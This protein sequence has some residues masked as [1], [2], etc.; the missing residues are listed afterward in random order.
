MAN[1]PDDPFEKQLNQGRQAL[2]KDVLKG[3][4]RTEY[5]ARIDWIARY[6]AREGSYTLIPSTKETISLSGKR[7]GDAIRQPYLS[8]VRKLTG[9]S[10]TLDDDYPLG[11][12]LV[13]YARLT[14]GLE[15]VDRQDVDPG[16]VLGRLVTRELQRQS[17]D[18]DTQVAMNL[19]SDI[20]SPREL[21]EQIAS[22]PELADQLEQVLPTRAAPKELVDRLGSV[23]IATRLWDHQLDAL[24]EWIAADGNGYVN[25]A[26]ATGKTVLGL[27]AVGYCSDSGSLHPADQN[28]LGEQFAERFGRSTP[29]AIGQN[30]ASD[31]LIVTTDELL[32]VQWARL[33]REHCNTPPEYTRIVDQTISL[34]WGDVDIRS[35]NSLNGVDPRDYRLAIFDEVHNYSSRGGWG[36]H[37]GRFIDS[38]CPVLALTGSVEE[39]IEQQFQRA[40]RPFPQVYRYTHEDALEDGVIPDFEWTLL[41]AGIDEGRSSTLSKLQKTET[42]F[43]DH[44]DWNG[45]GVTIRE[46]SPEYASLP[47]QV[48][49]ELAESPKSATGLGRALKTAGSKETAPTETLETLATGLSSRRTFWWNLRT[50]LEDIAEFAAEEMTAGRPVLILTRSYRE[51]DR[52]YK[53]VRSR[54]SAGKV[55]KL[56][57]DESAAEQDDRITTFD[58]WETDVKALIGPGDRIGTGN[59]IQSVEV[60]VNI[61]RPGSGM[62]ASLVQRLGRLLRQA[63][64]KDRVEFY[65]VLGVPPADAIIP[66]DGE[67]FVRNVTEFFVQAGQPDAEATS[68]A[69]PPSV[70]VRDDARE[71]IIEL[72][73]YGQRALAQPNAECDQY[74]KAYRDAIAAADGDAVL[75]TVE[76][77]REFFETSAEPKTGESLVSDPDGQDGAAEG[78][79]DNSSEQGNQQE[80]D[81]P[82]LAVEVKA[83]DGSAI[84]D[85]VVTVDGD[86]FGAHG[87]TN[88]LGET[89]FDPGDSGEY[90]VAVH[91]PEHRIETAHVTVSDESASATLTLQPQ[92]PGG[93]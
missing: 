61:A 83:T 44:V 69:K 58:E 86:A 49:Q 93:V 57:S 15:R 16:E 36:D 5:P 3:L 37:L 67:Q 7:F 13:Q 38:S 59:D 40:E 63:G 22:Y 52:F 72:E 20:H 35:A 50:D 66:S 14:L 33:F 2:K 51:A 90:L 75:D 24:A 28:A 78:P 53:E 19:R 60:G 76:W 73:R 47:T 32:G 45:D 64:E 11:R 68:M 56:G 70:L 1:N 85:A 71:G 41:Y 74:E 27:A 39:E 25:M 23:S 10:V 48:Q 92:S 79:T 81:T 55:Q 91:H 26:T 30:R 31:V 62:S 65:H 87:R 6:I 77:Y 8:G 82:A 84:S 4:S 42:L 54:T 43:D 89:E 21:V 17:S 29:P 80:T 88:I 9:A 46:D 34:P 18:A 12:L